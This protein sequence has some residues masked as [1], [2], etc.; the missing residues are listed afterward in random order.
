M[1]L[2]V[3][4]I[5]KDAVHPI[6]LISKNNHESLGCRICSLPERPAFSSGGL[7]AT[8]QQANAHLYGNGHCLPKL[9]RIRKE[10]HVFSR[11]T[12]K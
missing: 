11:K 12:A 10:K 9:S 3:D 8:P 7:G 1:I 6:F 4:S 5:Y 2:R